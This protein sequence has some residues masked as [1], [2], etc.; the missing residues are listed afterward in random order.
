MVDL[1]AKSPCDGMLPVTIGSVTLSELDFGPMTSI[2]PFKGQQKAVSAVMKEAHGVAYPSANRM[3]GKAGV[4]ARWFGQGQVLLSGSVA[5]ASLHNLAALTDQSDA[6]AVVEL[7]G[8][9]AA[10]VLARLVSIDLRT[11]EFK[12][13]HSVRCELMHMMASLTKTGAD[14]FQIMVFRSMAKTLVHD[15]TTAM[16]N[17]NAR[18]IA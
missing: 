15:L 2:A 12:R 7:K 5:D 18:V 1:I 6:W 14:A 4:Q 11:G 3:N 9:H 13:G 17:V 16:E 8:E 10:D